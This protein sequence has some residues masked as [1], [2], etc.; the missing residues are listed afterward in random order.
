MPA[1]NGNNARPQQK[2]PGTMEQLK[3]N[4]RKK[5]TFVPLQKTR[6][7]PLP[8]TRRCVPPSKRRRSVPLQQK[9][10]R[11]FGSPPKRRRCVPLQPGEKTRSSPKRKRC[12]HL[13]NTGQEVFICTKAEDV[14]TCKRKEKMC[15][16]VKRSRCV[17]LQTIKGNTIM[18]H[19]TWTTD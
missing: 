18:S 2:M 4:Q 10:R 1:P 3:S 11:R 14:S 15:S 7:V 8:K 6:C 5:R 17:P 9:K 12:V 16:F 19:G 13:Q